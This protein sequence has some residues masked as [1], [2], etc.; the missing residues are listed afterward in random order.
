MREAL[1]L[2]VW[3]PERTDRD[4][5]PSV[6][7]PTAP[8]ASPI[9]IWSEE[10]FARQQIQGLVRQVFLSNSSQPIRQVVFS[11]LD[12]DTNVR[13]LC[14]RVGETL[15]RETSEVV[16][17]LPECSRKQTAIE[18]ETDG[19]RRKPPL[20][21]QRMATRLHGN[22]WLLP[23]APLD[24]AATTSVHSYL[25]ELRREFEFSIVAAPPASESQAAIA[26]AEF[27]DGIILVLKA[28]RTRRAAT[29]NLMQSLEA[30]Q[31][32]V[33]GTVLTDR[34]FPMPERI[35]RRL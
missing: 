35:Y 12:A 1:N 22:L 24:G 18:N 3:E 8:A 31:V 16:A 7:L 15:A 17:I 34:V 9:R 2:E 5:E 28:H 25:E 21:V 26:M 19:V 14:V 10:S 29:G 6:A 20:S 32:R 27:A 23:P 4:T 13:S 30:A 11:A 33:L